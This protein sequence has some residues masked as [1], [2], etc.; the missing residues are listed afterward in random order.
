M[1]PKILESSYQGPQVYAEIWKRAQ[2]DSNILFE[3]TIR[4]ALETARKLSKDYGTMQTLVTGS[5]FLV[6]GALSLL[7]TANPQ[8]LESRHL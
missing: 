7:Q 3:P 4:G 2:P 6:G 5:L 8:G 1:G